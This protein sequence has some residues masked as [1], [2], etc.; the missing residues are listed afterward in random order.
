MNIQLIKEFIEKENLLFK[1][2]ASGIGISTK[3]KRGKETNEMCIVFYVNEK[4][5][6]SFLRND[7]IIPSEFDIKGE[8]VKTDIRV[9]TDYDLN[10]FTLPTDADIQKINK[11][12]D[13]EKFYDEDGNLIIDLNPLGMSKEL[14]ATLPNFTT[15]IAEPFDEYSDF[16][17]KTLSGERYLYDDDYRHNYD[18]SNDFLS[19]NPVNYINDPN[20]LLFTEQLTASDLFRN[21]VK[22]RPLSGGV[23]SIFLGRI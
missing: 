21:R 20:N 11:V 6:L 2:P 19:Y 1:Y 17:Q 4:K 12:K 15:M 18:I 22:A 10:N 8:K 14:L 7:E 5:H 23:S 13:Q 9:K 16:V 3:Q